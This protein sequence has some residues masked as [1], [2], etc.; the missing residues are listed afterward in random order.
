MEIDTA[1]LELLKCTGLLEQ[2]PPPPPNLGRHPA[3]ATATAA[4]LNTLGQKEGLI[5]SEQIARLQVLTS[6]YHTLLWRMKY[7]SGEGPRNE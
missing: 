3:L 6:M 2:P 7:D 1:P 5:A 4:Y